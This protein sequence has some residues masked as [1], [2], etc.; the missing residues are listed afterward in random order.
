M[1]KLDIN[2]LHQA[3]THMNEKYLKQKYPEVRDQKLG[4]CDACRVAKS[5]KAPVRKKVKDLDTQPKE[6]LD[7]VVSDLREMPTRG[8]GGMKHVGTAIDVVSGYTL[9]VYLSMK[10]QFPKEYNSIIAWFKNQAGRIFKCWGTDNGG[11]FVNEQTN[12]TNATE[13]IEHNK[14]P[15]HT[16]RKNGIAERF[17]RTMIEAVSAMLIFAGMEAC[18][19][20]ECTMYYVFLWNRSPRK[21]RN[22]KTPY[23]IFHKRKPHRVIPKVFGCLAYAH[24]N[25][26]AKSQIEKAQH[27]IFVG[28]DPSGRY[29]LVR[30]SDKARIVTDSATFVEYVFPLGKHK[31]LDFSN[32]KVL[33]KLRQERDISLENEKMAAKSVSEKSG[34]FR[35]QLSEPIKNSPIPDILKETPQT[36]KA[37]DLQLSTAGNPPQQTSS[38]PDTIDDTPELLS[39]SDSESDDDLFEENDPAIDSTTET[40]AGTS[41]ESPQ[42]PPLERAQPPTPTER[43]QFSYL[44]IPP[45]EPART[46]F[47]HQARQG[48]YEQD[49]RNLEDEFVSSPMVRRSQ[50]LIRDPTKTGASV[51]Q[52]EHLANTPKQAHRRSQRINRMD[53]E[54]IANALV[55]GRPVPKSYTHAMVSPEWPKWKVAIEKEVAAIHRTGSLEHV[56][57]L[58][59]GSHAIR[60]RWVFKIKPETAQEPEIYKARLVAQ[61]FRQKFGVDFEETFAAVAKMSSLRTMIALAAARN[62]RLTKLDVSNAFLASDID[63]DVYL[64]PPPGFPPGGFFK[65]RKALYGL[66]QSPRLWA[67]TLTKEFLSLG[68]KPLPT[69]TCIFKHHTSQ[70]TILVV[71]DDCIIEGNDEPLRKL[72]ETTLHRKFGIKAFDKVEAFIGLQLEHTEAGIKIFQEQYIEELLAKF[73]MTDCNT[74]ETPAAPNAEM[75]TTLLGPGNVYRNLVGSLLYL[76]ASRPDIASAVVQ[77]SRHLNAPTQGHL[78]AAKRVLRYLAGTPRKGV[79]FKRGAIP[80]LICYSDSDWAGCQKTRKSTSGYVVYFAGG[81]VSWK[82]KL[83]VITALSS[84]EAEYVALTEAVK[85]ILWLVQHFGALGIKLEVPIFVFGDNTAAIALAKNPVFHQRSKHI[86]IKHHFLR[87]HVKAGTVK[88]AYVDTKENVADVLTKLTAAPVFNR[89]VTRLVYSAVL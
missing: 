30:L 25:Y 14:T 48:L 53:L 18:W 83:Q 81:P 78:K 84:C 41:H 76:L 37:S 85:E 51:K 22:F 65:L 32:T 87:D 3:D 5:H 66:K 55:S 74:A 26:R 29:K 80:R 38:A 75:N 69:D 36:I 44:N 58:P 13:G 49:G 11:E 6:V 27:C 31:G 57:F 39:D 16:S 54:A 45:P 79:N 86:D 4:D 88:L 20:V 71:V 12:K 19:W 9:L 62:S 35:A 50:R 15:P 59:Q 70:T 68:F 67:E 34:S 42:L 8:T 52:L 46:T 60:C 1:T 40:K 47:S 10:S 72:V 73:G 33:W 17:N 89:L 2:Q 63:R 56:D 64:H 28:I 77:L 43:K 23:E 7:K 61:G 82:S 21:N 24:D